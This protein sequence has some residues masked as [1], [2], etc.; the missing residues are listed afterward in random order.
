M[1]IRVRD[2][3]RLF[4]FLP[5]AQDPIC[6]VCSVPLGELMPSHARHAVRRQAEAEAEA[7]R[8][9]KTALL[10]LV[11]EETV[12]EGPPR[13]DASNEDV[14]EEFAF[15]SHAR[16][17]RDTKAAQADARRG[18]VR[19]PIGSR[20]IQEPQTT[21]LELGG[22]VEEEVEE[23]GEVVLPHDMESTLVDVPFYLLPLSG[24]DQSRKAGFIKLKVRVLE[25]EGFVD[26]VRLHPP[27]RLKQLYAEK[28]CKVRL[29]LTT[30]LPYYLTTLLPYYL[31]TLLTY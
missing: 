13:P 6:G 27:P 12:L 24:R 28:Q 2:S 16:E 10:E 29:Y 20:S 30:L 31:T 7:E 1:G 26:M 3:A 11:T 14:A 23:E 17:R 15:E 9:R 19:E 8:R 25:E 5:G 18:G 21:D 22:E 4:S